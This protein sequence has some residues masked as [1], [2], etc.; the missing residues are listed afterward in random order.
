MDSKAAP[1]KRGKLGRLLVNVPAESRSQLDEAVLH[2][3]F[4]YRKP[5]LK[6]ILNVR[7][8]PTPIPAR[9]TCTRRALTRSKASISDGM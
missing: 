3:F 7:R 1:L 6:N 5:R 2:V 9:R 8:A 4:A